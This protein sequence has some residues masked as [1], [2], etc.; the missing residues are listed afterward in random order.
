MQ[1]IGDI[2]DTAFTDSEFIYRNALRSQAIASALGLF[3][4]AE[5]L[6]VG[7]FVDDLIGHGNADVTKTQHNVSIDPTSSQLHPP[8]Q[9]FSRSG[10]IAVN[11]QTQIYDTNYGKL[12]TAEV[13]GTADYIANQSS[14]GA[15]LSPNPLR[16]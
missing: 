13:Q 7:V 8:F 11:A 12:A 15:T 3:P 16:S 4:G 6:D 1:D 14:R 5:A 2:E 10:T 9:T